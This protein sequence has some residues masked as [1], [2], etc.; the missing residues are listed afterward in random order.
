MNRR[1]TPGHDV[2]DPGHHTNHTA[3]ADAAAVSA[4]DHPGTGRRPRSRRGSKL[5]AGAAVVALL[6]AAGCGGDDDDGTTT[7]SGVT[8]TTVP[9]DTTTS[10]AGDTSTSAPST[11]TGQDTSSTTEATDGST[12]DGTEDAAVVLE[13]DGLGIVETTSGSTTH[14]TFGTELV[15]VSG[16]ATAV[17]GEP[18]E[19]VDVPECP[20]GPAQTVRYD[21]GLWLVAMDGVFVGWSVGPGGDAALTTA[22]G[23]GLGSTVGDVRDVIADVTVEE[24][25][26]GFEMTAG[27]LHAVVDGDT[28]DGAITDLWAG[29]V[30]IFR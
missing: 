8:S 20:P 4:G 10:T 6:M 12:P 5:A 13:P 18:V 17:L 16:A 7:T 25:T 2:P 28:D 23:I 19:E 21:D 26:L 24:T 30:C 1:L 29:T 9:G 14:L 22:A 15:A 27:D 3:E 11:T